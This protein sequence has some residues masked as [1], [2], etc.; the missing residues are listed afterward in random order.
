MRSKSSSWLSPVRMS[1]GE[2]VGLTVHEVARICGA[3]HGGQIV[4][5][6][7]VCRGMAAVGDVAFR[8]LGSFLL[9]GIA[10]P[11]TLFQVDR[12]GTARDFPPPRDVV[13]AGGARVTVWRR[14]ASPPSRRPAPPLDAKRVG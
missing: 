2:Y 10:A 11:R 3:A 12:P 8:E 13:R 9:R 4:C 14:D 7:D 1:G 5:S 6:S